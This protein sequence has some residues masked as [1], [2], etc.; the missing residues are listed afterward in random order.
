VANENN[1]IVLGNSSIQ[2]LYCAQTSITAI[3]D[4][5]FKKNIKSD[6]HGLDF[7]MKLKPVSYNLDITSLNAYQGKTISESDQKSVMQAE[8]IVHNGFLA[9]DVEAAAN[10]VHYNFSGLKTPDNARDIYGLG[11]TDFVVPL[12]K[13][14]QELN[15]AN[16]SLKAENETLKAQLTNLE[17]S[18]MNLQASVVN[19]EKELALVKTLMNKKTGKEI[20]MTK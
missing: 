2:K 14:V 9:Q 17:K 1:V 12:V 19:N 8:Q 7:I 3:S 6:I 20:A 11:Y 13:S 16:E 10:E 18:I 15:D 5:R 4:G